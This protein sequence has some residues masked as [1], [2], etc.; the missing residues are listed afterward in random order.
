MLD[1]SGRTGIVYA[2][3]SPTLLPTATPT[4]TASTTPTA[5]PSPSLTYN[6]QQGWNLFAYTDAST[7][8]TTAAQLLGALLQQSGGH[9]AA[10]Y[11]LT[12]NAWRP[13]L[14][15]ANGTISTPDFPL[16][17]IT[18]YLLYSDQAVT[19]SLQAA[20]HF[21]PATTKRRLSPDTVRTL[22]RLLPPVPRLP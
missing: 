5:T 10:I 15:D 3:E 13:S 11:G 21:V 9:V 16:Q 6:I 20:A 12:N 22:R 1:Q 7:G 8:I 4:A 2:F 19:F 17:P 18:G 14:I